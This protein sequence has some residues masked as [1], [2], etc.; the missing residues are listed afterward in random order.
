MRA[1]VLYG[2]VLGCSSSS[3]SVGLP[4]DGTI[5][6]ITTSPL[7]LTPAFSPS[8]DDYYVRCVAGDNTLT[9][10]VDA[11]S[12]TTATYLVVEDQAITI[13]DYW[14]RCLPHDFPG[15]T[16]A[17]HPDVG[18]PTPGYYLVNSSAYAAVIDGN[19]TPVWYDHAKAACNVDSLVPGEISYLP[20]A[21]F[22]YAFDPSVEIELDV[23][24]AQPTLL[25]SPD[26]PTDEHE[27]RLLPNGDYLLFADVVVPG[28]DLT[29]L[30]GFGSND[31][32]DDCKIEEL[33]PSGDLVWSWLA[34]DHV[35]PVQESLAPAT[36]L[37]D[38]ATVVDWFHCNAID[39]A[40]NGDLLVS[41]RHASAV[42][43]IDRATGR[44]AWK[45]GGTAYNKD[46]AAHIQVTGDSEGGFN[47]QHDARFA[48]NGDITLFDDHGAD[49]GT[50]SSVARGIELAL[51]H[52]AG[53][54][55]I[56]WQFL[57]SAESQYMG[58][59]RRYADG[60]SV[61]G[62]GYVPG[63]ARILTETDGSGNDLLDI[64]FNLPVPTDAVSYRA[65][66]VAPSQ[67][68]IATLRAT[69]A[70]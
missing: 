44:I 18:T 34:S 70:R 22:P 59:F 57:G 56:V 25:K 50:S 43:Y 68:D 9:V 46:G 65:V 62:W 11:A 53:T 61:I 23:L 2:A 4:I 20:N 41:A 10:T 67:L 21:E 29:G 60:D 37:I 49:G 3:Q 58:S 13:G 63:V 14:I 31:S 5:T 19:G 27:L 51:D 47:L 17:A 48:A 54:A 42:Y 35:D 40:A 7:E 33:S 45:L 15:I 8:I 69:T 12:T 55:Q 52:D 38:N 64:Q 26:A 6:Q 39:V 36:N 32:I 30:V 28:V 24:G 16:V 66:K 1:I